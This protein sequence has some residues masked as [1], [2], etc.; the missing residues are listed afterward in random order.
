MSQPPSILTK[1]NLNQELLE[2]QYA[3]RGEVVLRSQ[4]LRAALKNGDKLPF[5]EL[6]PCNIG[7]PQAVGQEP[8]R[9]YREV[10]AL[11]ECPHLLSDER[12]KDLFSEEA[13]VRAKS[14]L[15]EE[16][17]MGA[18]TNSKGFASVRKHVANYIT[19]RDGHS[20]DPENIFL[21]PGASAGAFSILRAMASSSNIGV[22][23]PIPQYPLY[24]AL[25]TLLGVHRISYYLDEDNDWALN[26]SELRRSLQEARDS[27]VNVRA[28]V[29]INPGNPT[30]AVLNRENIQE[31][32]HFCH[33]EGLILMADEVYQENVYAQGKAFHSVRKVMLDMGAPYSKE[34]SAFSF[35][36]TSKGLIGECGH[37]GGYLEC[38]NVP[39]DV[40]GQL[41]KQASISLC[42]NTVGQLLVDLMVLPPPKD[43]EAFKQFQEQRHSLFSSLSDRASFVATKL[44]ELEG[45]RCTVPQ[46][47]MY[48]FPRIDMPAKAIQEAEKRGKTADMFYCLELL[49]STGIIAV[50][51]S[52]FGQRPG[53]YHIRLT[54]LPQMELI[55]KMIDRFA[56]FHKSFLS[57]YS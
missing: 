21:A 41:Y 16:Q 25:T 53:T 33:Q 37:R 3:V 44:Q 34:L 2:A 48:L 45:I 26:V 38:T 10:I 15:K 36:S 17:G 42:P 39:S 51:G 19:D 20:C 32:I 5:D 8:I 54:F 11:A 6:I 46:G 4:E 12:T 49:E 50:P 18:Y 13:I 28:M 55:L 40:L 31:V 47:A 29:L 57:K 9:F 7:N 22:M 14:I 43:S 30:G 23:V 56:T 1:D 24:S 52:G 35:H 27:G